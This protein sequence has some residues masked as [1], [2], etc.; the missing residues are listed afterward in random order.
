MTSQFRPALVLLLVLTLLCGGVYPLLV[1]GAGKL[2]FPAQ[3]AGSL[4]T[5]GGKLR[6]ASLIGQPFSSPRYFWGRPSATA[7]M[8]YN[9]A[10]SSGSNQGPLNPA[11]VEAVKGRIDALRAADPGNQAPVP[12]DLVTASASGL[13]PEISPAAMLYQLGRVARARGASPAAL[14]PLVARH[15]RQPLLGVFGEARV[16]VLELNLALDRDFP[17]R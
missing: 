15:T 2:A 9:A 16:N 17:V 10:G 13:D 4:I 8:P 6:G 5:D 11:L 12:V 7:P 3:A 1:T 14:Q